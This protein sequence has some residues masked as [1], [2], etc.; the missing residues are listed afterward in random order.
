[1]SVALKDVG[2]AGIGLSLPIHC[3]RTNQGPIPSYRYGESKT[4]PLDAIGSGKLGLL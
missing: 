4:V 1:M 2:C 3:L